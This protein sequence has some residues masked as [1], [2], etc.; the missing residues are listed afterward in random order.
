MREARSALTGL[1]MSPFSREPIGS[2][3]ELAAEAA[4]RAIADA[5][6]AP[7]A[8][9]GL[10]INQSAAAPAGALSLRLHEDIGLGGLNLLT[11]V[12]GKGSSVLQMVQQ[13][14]LA[15]AAGMAR[16]VLCVFADA[17]I[18]P[19]R[20]GSQAF[21]AASVLSGIEGWEARYGLFGPVGAY[22]LL[23]RYYMHRHAMSEADLGGQAVASHA[24]A[25]LNPL[26]LK[27]R[28]LS[29]SDYLG[30]RCIASPLRVHDCAFPVNGGAAVVVSALEGLKDAPHAPVFVHGMGQGHAGVPRMAHGVL[31]AS[32]ALFAV[33]QG[34][35]RTPGTEAGTRAFAMAGIDASS[36]SQCQFYDAFSFNVTAALEDYGLVPR[37]EGMRFIAQGHTSPGGK[38]PVNTGGGQ[39]AG[40][41]LQGMTPLAEAVVQGRAEAGARQAGNDVI[42]VNGSGGTLEYHAALVLSPHR[43]LR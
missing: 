28:L 21:N 27:P 43:V 26:S 32:H 36:V 4:R 11:L 29:I 24:W 13:A 31:D 16:H 34:E 37:G 39:L 22:A 23:A 20:G 2:P 30:S 6:L 3:R 9:D 8:I 18:A 40:F 14:T 1:G 25:A 15:V 42:L 10:L 33:N 38:L 41:Y 7:G 19:G 5:G 12:E 17:P 35:F